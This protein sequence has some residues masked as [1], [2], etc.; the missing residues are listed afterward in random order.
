MRPI[1]EGSV[2]GQT[3]LRITENVA[4]RVDRLHV[5]IAILAIMRVAIRVNFSS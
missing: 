1:L 5:F 4:G 3:L 2:V